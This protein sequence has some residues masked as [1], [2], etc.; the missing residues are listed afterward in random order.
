M[1]QEKIVV[2][3]CL[4]YPEKTFFPLNHLQERIEKMLNKDPNIS[5]QILGGGSST[6][7]AALAVDYAKK[8][9]GKFP[10]EVVFLQSEARLT[11]AE[12]VLLIA[13]KDLFDRVES[14]PKTAPE[15]EPAAFEKFRKKTVSNADTIILFGSQDRVLCPYVRS[16]KKEKEIYFIE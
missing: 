10:N 14:M 3:A 5:I 1:E 4:D 9:I 11:D 6:C 7:F 15:Q 12:T 8:K 16:M 2:I 13:K